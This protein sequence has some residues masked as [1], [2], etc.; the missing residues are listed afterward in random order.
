MTDAPVLM[1]TAQNDRGTS[2]AS[3]VMGEGQSVETLFD[4]NLEDV[5][6]VY[7]VAEGQAVSINHAAQLEAVSFGVT[8]KSD[9]A[10]DVTLT[11]LDAVVGS[12]YVFDAVDGT[13]TA[14]DEGST[15]S[16]MPNEY[17]RY[18][19]TLSTSLGEVKEGL[20]EGV[21]VSVHGGVVSIT[22]AANLGTVRALGIGGATLFHAADCGTSV[23]FRLQQGVYV[24]ETDGPAGNRTMKLVV[25]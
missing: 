20:T 11:G 3:V 2:K 10:V 8:C 24:I 21:K 14:V 5:P 19:L 9:E 18:F 13:T 22:A 7:T 25:R 6:M 15:I 16:V 1:L 23:Q 12:L 17:G 4:S